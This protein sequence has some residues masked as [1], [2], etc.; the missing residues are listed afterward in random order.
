MKILAPISRYT[1][2]PALIKNGADEFYMGIFSQDWH[3]KNQFY[4]H[5]NRRDNILANTTSF[6]EAKQVINSARKNNKKVNVVFNTDT[7]FSGTHQINNELK[8]IIEIKPDAIIAKDPIIIKLIRK[9]TKSLPIHLSSLD[10]VINTKS[11]QFWCKNFK[12][13]RIILPR[14]LT[15]NEISNLAKNLPQIEFEVFIYDDNCS[16]IDGLCSSIHFM[17]PDGIEFVC[18]REPLYTSIDKKLEKNFQ[19]IIRQKTLCRACFLSLFKEQKNI[20]SGKIVGRDRSARDKG[21]MVLFIKQAQNIAQNYPNHL[22]FQKKAKLLH[23]IIFKKN[24]CH[25]CP[26]APKD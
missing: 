9:L 10:Q 25:I 22:Q 12:I 17:K 15:I 2:L 14:N 24:Y 8:K 5:L 16:N 20:V 23:Q 18:E 4:N 1:E 21:L 11:A 3:K 26:Y 7:I 19:T 13:N 6:L